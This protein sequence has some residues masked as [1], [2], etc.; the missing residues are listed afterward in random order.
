[1]KD[2]D[3][4]IITGSN[5][6][7][8][9]ELRNDGRFTFTGRILTDNAVKT[10]EPIFNWLLRFKG[11]AVL[12]EIKLDYINTSASMQLFAFLKQLEDNQTIKRIL[13]KWYYDIDDDDHLE[14][15]E[16][17]EDKLKRTHFEFIG[18]NGIAA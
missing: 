13:V 7:P 6:S 18:V 17:F 1:M 2:M 14:T 9:V 4:L 11:D 12:F 10:F 15:G 5:V 16:F 8:D 3:D